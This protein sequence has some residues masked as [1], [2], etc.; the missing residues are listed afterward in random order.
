MEKRDIERNR[1]SGT[2]GHN[3]L[4]FDCTEVERPDVCE[5]RASDG[6]R[7]RTSERCSQQAGSIA[8]ENM[9]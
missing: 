5:T 3:G 6:S 1:R 9:T 2:A 8:G 7:W 4:G